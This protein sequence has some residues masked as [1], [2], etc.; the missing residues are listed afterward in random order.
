MSISL[1]DCRRI[2]PSALLLS[3]ASL[4]AHLSLV[5]P[6]VGFYS[7]L[8]YIHTRNLSPSH[9]SLSLVRSHISHRA[10]PPSHPPTLPP[11]HISLAPPVASLGPERAAAPAAVLVGLA[12][13]GEA[14]R[15]GTLSHARRFRALLIAISIATAINTPGRQHQ[16]GACDTHSFS[17]PLILS[18]ALIRSSVARSIARS[19]PSHLP[20][21]GPEA[22][23]ARPRR[24]LPAGSYNDIT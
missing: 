19:M 16:Q 2:L 22:A 4:T 12:P 17:H 14:R 15:P 8:F 21:P 18:L 11:S 5:S 10:L 7:F 23:A 20:D 6:G 1:F 9:I 13:Q 3:L 24:G